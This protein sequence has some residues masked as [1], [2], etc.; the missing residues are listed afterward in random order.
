MSANRAGRY[1]FYWYLIS[2]PLSLYLMVL[3]EQRGVGTE[4]VDRATAVTGVSGMV[5]GL[6]SPLLMNRGILRRLLMLI[7]T[8][9][10]MFIYALIWSCFLPWGM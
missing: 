1:C 6:I 8:V 2:I 7:I 10:V 4:V 9:A 3:L 5:L